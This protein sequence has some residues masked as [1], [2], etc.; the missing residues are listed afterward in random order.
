M[1]IYCYKL[2]HA[3]E[4]VEP[5][6]A[7]KVTLPI[8]Q[9][10]LIQNGRVMTTNLEMAISADLPEAQGESLC[11]PHGVVSNFI[12]YIPN[13][14]ILDITMDG[15]KATIRAGRMVTT[16]IGAAPGDFPLFPRITPDGE[17]SV[18][19]DRLVHALMGAV[20]GAAREDSRPVLNGVCLTFRDPIEVAGA[21]GF[22][23][24]WNEAP[25]KLEAP[26]GRR[27]WPW[28]RSG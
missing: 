22:R 20:P 13:T 25:I 1:Q 24:T 4:L 9:N 23:L 26:D 11:L 18:D 27:C 14:D 28:R 17:W 3:L 15:V 10:F 6:V 12:Q 21:D 8:T 2:K 5:A 7:R 19:E 16:V